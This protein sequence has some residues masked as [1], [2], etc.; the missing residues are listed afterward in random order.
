MRAQEEVARIGALLA[1]VPLSD[2][3]QVSATARG[4]AGVLAAAAERVD[5]RA[6]HLL[7][8]ASEQLYRAAEREPR[9]RPPVAPPEHRLATVARAVLTVQTAS[10]GG[11]A[12]TMVLLHQVLRL[13]QTI[14]RT[15]ETAGRLAQAAGPDHDTARP[16]PGR[17]RP[18]NHPG[19]EYG[20][21]DRTMSELDEHMDMAGW[22][23]QAM[24]SAALAVAQAAAERRDRVLRETARQAGVDAQEVQRRAQLDRLTQAGAVPT[25]AE[26]AG[27]GPLSEHP[28]QDRS[29]VVAGLRAA[30]PA[31][32]ATGWATATALGADGPG[33]D[34]AMRA[35]GAVGTVG[36]W[37]NGAEAPRLAGMAQTTRAG[38]SSLPGR[39]GSQL[40]RGQRHSVEAAR[41]REP[42]LER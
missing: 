7:G 11:S 42:G 9:Q 35:V 4:A 24:L 33:W 16:R 13:A 19:Y 8:R 23:L 12:G 21:G 3:A 5:G 22:H 14:Q 32:L 41:Q 20:S 29:D 38:R 28:A 40:R 27:R 30:D 39:P 25:P 17:H 15:H 36:A 26:V 37:R 6:A 2:R 1:G 31:E 34:E 18:G 10:R